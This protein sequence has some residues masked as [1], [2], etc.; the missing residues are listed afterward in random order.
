MKGPFEAAVTGLVALPG[1][2]YWGAFSV[3][4]QAMNSSP[5]VWWGQWVSPGG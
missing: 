1:S 4:K 3:S 2:N 5:K